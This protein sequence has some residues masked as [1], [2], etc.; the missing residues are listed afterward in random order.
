MSTDYGSISF[1]IKECISLFKLIFSHFLDLWV[2]MTTPIRVTLNEWIENFEG[3]GIIGTVASAI[4]RF[5]TS[6][7]GDMSI[8][9][10]MIGAGLSLYISY[11]LYLWFTQ[12]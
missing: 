1:I 4:L 10:L 7:L 8:L 12:D 2:D 6:F 3:L 5:F 9:S 11:Q